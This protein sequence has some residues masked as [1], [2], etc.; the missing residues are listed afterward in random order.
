MSYLRQ[1]LC[2]HYWVDS[3][4]SLSKPIFSRAWLKVGLKDW[5]TNESIWGCRKCEKVKTFKYDFIPLNFED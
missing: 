4:L 5:R 2:T 3:K 1:L